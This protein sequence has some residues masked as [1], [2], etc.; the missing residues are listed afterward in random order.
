MEHLAISCRGDHFE[1]FSSNGSNH[2]LMGGIKVNIGSNYAV[3]GHAIPGHPD[4]DTGGLGSFPAGHTNLF[5]GENK[6]EANLR[7]KR[8]A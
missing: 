6:E 5:F 3:P 8:T 2:V 1:S 4:K 7:Q